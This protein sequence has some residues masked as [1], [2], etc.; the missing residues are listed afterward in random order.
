MTVEAEG[1]G[2]RFGE[3]WGVREATLSVE[4]GTVAVLAGPNGAGKTTTTRIL[5]TY[6]R[7]DK[8]WAR[9]CGFDVVKEYREVRRRI[10]YLPQ[11]YNV[12]NDLTP[13]ELVTAALMMRG[14]SYFSARREAR[15]WL[16]ELGLWEIRNRRLWQLSGGEKRRA[17]VASVLAEPAEVYFLDEPT[18]GIDVEGRYEVLKA[19]RKAASGGA[20][21]FMTTHNLSEAQLA[22]DRVIFINSG[23]T[24]LTGSPAE[25][26][27]KFP[28]K[29]KAVIDSPSQ[30]LRGFPHLSLG[31]K[32]VVYS[33][34]RAELYSILEELKVPVHA[35]REVDLEDVYL[36]AV[37]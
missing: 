24:V 1:L 35:V 27:E 2:K 13:E 32:V 3:V 26:L 8:G 33:S 34:S 20:T 18:T 17:V 10:A 37:R 29:Y 21:V 23:R 6:Y 22:A 16:E 14:Y 12:A 11:G 5:T 31:D 25:L 9:V 7:P 19:V 4:R 15:R 36:H 28:W 30:E